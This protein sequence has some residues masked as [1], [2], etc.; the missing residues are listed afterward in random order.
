MRRYLTAMGVRT[1]SFPVAVWGFS[2][3]H[4]VL[5]TVAALL[6]TLIPS[7]AVMVANAVDHRQARPAA[8]ASPVQGL[9]ARGSG[10]VDRGDAEGA[11]N[12]STR[13]GSG[14]VVIAG[15]LVE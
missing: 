2:A 3:E 6:A 9:A 10:A 5:A 7:V 13:D 1:I 12:G 11:G 14:P 8:P 4:Y 15:S